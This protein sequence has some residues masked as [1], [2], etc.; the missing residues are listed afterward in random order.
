MI[1]FLLFYVWPVLWLLAVIFSIFI[2]TVFVKYGKFSQPRKRGNWF[3][4]FIGVMVIAMM[5]TISAGIFGYGPMK[6]NHPHPQKIQEQATGQPLGG[7]G[8][9]AW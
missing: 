1:K 7:G 5:L 3:L 8:G 4:T 9:G 2:V 6:A